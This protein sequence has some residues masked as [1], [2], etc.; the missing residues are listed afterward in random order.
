MPTS[1]PA[2]SC[3]NFSLSLV[4]VQGDQVVGFVDPQSGNIAKLADGVFQNFLGSLGTD[5]RIEPRQLNDHPL[6]L[7]ILGRKCFGLG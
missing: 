1:K 7:Q 3:F 2:N 4:F 5:F 6:H